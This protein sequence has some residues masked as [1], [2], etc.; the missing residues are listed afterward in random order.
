MS[1]TARTVCAQPGAHGFAPP[2][3]ARTDDADAR[4]NWLVAFHA[5]DDRLRRRFRDAREREEMELMSRPRDARESY[6]MLGALLG[7]LPPAAIFYRM[8]GN[9]IANERRF[10]SAAGL[11]TLLALMNLVCWLVG[12]WFGSK[13]AAPLEG[14]ERASWL[15]TLL[16]ALFA[17]FV[18]GVVTGFAGGLP[19]FGI[20]AFFGAMC[21]VP[22]GVAGFPVFTILR[23][24]LA[25]GGMIETRHLRP[26]AWGVALTI[27]A[28]ILGA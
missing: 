24:L 13:L 14:A 19:F 25:R 5:Y 11:F 18:W 1:A 28:L 17:G 9:V 15:K 8:F 6:R 3:P 2:A 22:V 27:A 16:V 20:G 7:L 12:R 26:L 23:R 4:L 21:A 10:A